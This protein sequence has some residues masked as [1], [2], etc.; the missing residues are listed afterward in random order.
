MG[1]S[2]FTKRPMRFA[3]QAKRSAGCRRARRIQ[4][5]ES[6][7]GVGHPAGFLCLKGGPPGA[8]GRGGATRTN[9]KSRST[10][11]RQ[12]RMQCKPVRVRDSCPNL[13]LNRQQKTRW[14]AAYRVLSISEAEPP[15]IQGSRK[16][17]RRNHGATHPPHL[18]G[19][20][21]CL[22]CGRTASSNFS[23][24]RPMTSGNGQF[25]EPRD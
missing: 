25:W 16:A 19:G 4:K 11:L 20:R 1:F 14:L 17:V 24:V 5:N 9:P 6:L 18:R 15:D 21:T 23:C 8:Q 10:A 13:Q 22:A 12:R 3:G 7:R 2:S